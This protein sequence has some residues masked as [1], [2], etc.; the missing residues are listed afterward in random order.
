MINVPRESGS[1]SVNGDW[2][3]GSNNVAHPERLPDGFARSVINMDVRDG[4]LE[5]RQGMQQVYAANTAV[6]GVL[7][8]GDK[9]LI[10]DGSLLVEFDTVAG[11]TRTLRTIAPDGVFAGTEHNGVLYF[12]TTDECLEYDGSRVRRWGVPDAANLFSAYP[13]PGGLQPGYYR[14]AITYS[15]ADGREGGTGSPLIV[16]TEQG[17]LAVDIPEPP[18]GCTTNLYIGSNSGGNLYLQTSAASAQTYTANLL[19]DDTKVLETFNRY[20]PTPAGI[21]KSHNAVIAMAYGDTLYMT[22]PMRPHL[23]DRVRGFFKY[24]APIGEVVS[25]GALYVSADK[26]YAIADA[27]TATPSQT[28]PLDYP[29]I[30]G[31]GAELP[32]GSGTWATIRGQ[33]VLKDGTITLA[34][35]QYFVPAP[36]ERGAAGVMD[37]GGDTRVVTTTQVQRGPNR[38]AAADF[39]DGEIKLP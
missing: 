18:V 17:G 31:T 9:L 25:A 12:C 26:Q 21:V 24:P 36:A 5:L 23:V 39:F 32:D 8:L 11:T 2:S 33:A 4:R 28:A 38:L 22:M 3:K 27:E 1:T 19:R 13:A 30:P 37:V 6:R 34:T 16:Y 20:A 14:A 35:G 10:A 7:A 15:D 29:A